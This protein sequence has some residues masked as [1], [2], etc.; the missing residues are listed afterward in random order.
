MHRIVSVKVSFIKE[1]T[2][3]KGGRTFNLKHLK[4]QTCKKNQQQEQTILTEEKGRAL[5]TL[6]SSMRCGTT[7]TKWSLE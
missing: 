3:T 1:L 6:L 7:G 2:F 4:N 5:R